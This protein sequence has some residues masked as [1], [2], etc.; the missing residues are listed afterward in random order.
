MNSSVIRA[1]VMNHEGTKSTKKKWL[2]GF[3]TF[4][5]FVVKS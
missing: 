3:V 1:R 5:F 2:F 4:A